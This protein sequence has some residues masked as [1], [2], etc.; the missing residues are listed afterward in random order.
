MTSDDG[1][2]PVTRRECIGGVAAGVAGTAGCLSLSG[3]DAEP[4]REAR[5]TT[6]P[7]RA[8][9]L[10]FGTEFSENGIRARPLAASVQR[11][12]HV[13]DGS[14]VH[15]VDG[16]QFVFVDVATG[17]SPG[18]DPPV[19]GDF[20]FDVD[21]RLYRG[22]T[23]PPDLDVLPTPDE[24]ESHYGSTAE[25]G[26]DE[27]DIYGGADQRGW[28]GFA[29]P[30]GVEAVPNLV[31]RPTEAGR[32]FAFWQLPDA[33]ADRLRAPPASLSVPS[34]SLPESV[35]AGGEIRA[36]VTAENA[37]EAEGRLRVAL[38]AAGTVT[39]G[40]VTVGPGETNTWEGS[41]AAPATGDAVEVAVRTPP[42]E[43]T[44]SVPI[45]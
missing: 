2:V 8:I 36:S 5:R 4:P 33:P 14:T 19:P 43:V 1:T 24:F 11:S 44:R 38:D 41:V 29:L 35:G 32:P 7:E 17:N 12:V 28:V 37:G 45:E 39:T 23:T 6:Y 13:R 20:A 42:R 9:E 30:T 25:T 15:A 10:E 18:I 22:W 34:V 27:S 40:G 3:G 16:R 26:G 31:L 21:D